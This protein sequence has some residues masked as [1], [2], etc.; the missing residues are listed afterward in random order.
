MITLTRRNDGR[1]Q[2]AVIINGKKKYFYGKKKSDVLKKIQE[3]EEQQE[4]GAMFRD[5]AEA[6]WEEHEKTLVHNTVQSYKPAKDRAIEFFHDTP[7]KDILPVHISKH[8]K[9]F[10]MTH[11]E[12]TVKTQLL[13]YSLI[14]KYAVNEG[15]VLMNPANDL[16]IHGG[17][18]SKKILPPS[19]EDISRVKNSTGCTFGMFAYWALYT[20]MRRGELLALEWDD[21]DLETRT[22]TINKSLYHVSNHPKIK[23]PK[24]ETSMSVIP[25]LDKLAEKLPK[26]RPS[27][28]VF[29]NQH[30]EYMSETQFQRMWELYC[31]ESGVSA[32]PHQFRHAYAT[33][34][35]E[36]GIPPEKMQILL[37]HAQLSTTMDIYREIREEKVKSIHKEVYSIDII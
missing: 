9:D 5:V 30:G 32:T 2:Q 33:M 6:W 35:F 11:A 8:L 15:Y 31:K 25:I 37:R 14:F 7:I 26:R 28:I 19:S 24:T 23:T 16:S 1:W 20:G 17:R 22:I 10:A 13:I 18:S 29:P 3:Y 12:K 21:V 4:C 36:A 27:G 34:L